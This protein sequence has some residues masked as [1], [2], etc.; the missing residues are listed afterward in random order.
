MYIWN[1]KNNVQ[2]R[3]T[4]FKTG[5]ASVA[6]IASK[7]TELGVWGRSKK[8]VRGFRCPKLAYNN[9]KANSFYE[10]NFLSRLN[11]TNLLE[12]NVKSSQIILS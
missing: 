11:D 5:K 6:S 3:R 2:A 4:L 1:H 12:I 10:A 8:I 9:P 7:K